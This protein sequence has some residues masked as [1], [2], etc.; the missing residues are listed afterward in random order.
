VRVRSARWGHAVDC[1]IRPAAQH[2][3][4]Q[5]RKVLVKPSG[6]LLLRP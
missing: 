1:A 2:L 3:V 4:S 5:Q 6:Q